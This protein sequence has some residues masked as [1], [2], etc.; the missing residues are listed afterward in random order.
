MGWF[1]S[2]KKGKPPHT[3]YPDILHWREG[4]KVFCWNVLGAMNQWKMDWGTYSKYSNAHSAHGKAMFT[5][6]SVDKNGV[7]YLEDE[8]GHLVE[9][10]FYR[11]VKRSRNET[12]LTRERKRRVE[13][14]QEYMQL[15]RDFQKAYDELQR[16]DS[17]RGRISLENDV[18]GTEDNRMKKPG[19]RE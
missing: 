19:I 1:T 9:F 13:E 5:F 7:I 12:M 4:D 16:A 3:W 18:F 15:M 6:K 8:D 14:S 2:K 17:G 11:F 10:E